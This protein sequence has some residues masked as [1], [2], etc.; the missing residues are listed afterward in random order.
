MKQTISNTVSVIIA[1]LLLTTALQSCS[2]LAKNM[3][4]NLAMQTATVTV[5]LIPE[6]DTRSYHLFGVG[7]ETYNIDSF[8]KAN[9]LGML[10]VSN[11]TSIKLQACTLILQNANA[12]NNFANLL[13]CT[14]SITD[15]SDAPY[16]IKVINNPDVFSTTLSLP[17]DTAAQLK[18]FL[19]SGSF[20]YSLGGQ[21]RRAT[22]DTLQ[23]TIQFTYNMSVQG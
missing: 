11:I 21:L 23:C 13:S 19:N 9:T 15:E 14:A 4:Y 3:T 8:I 18:Q 1:A 5:K 22:K 17:V 6:S 2:K 12:A 20:N 16:E 7:T 10:G